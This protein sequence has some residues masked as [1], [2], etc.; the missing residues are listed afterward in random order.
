MEMPNNSRFSVAPER[1]IQR[2]T[3]D[4]PQSY[5]T[6][7]NAGDLIPIYWDEILPGDTVEMHN[8]MVVRESTPIHPVFGN[9]NVETFWF[10]VPNRLLWDDWEHFITGGLDA[11][12]W[13]TP[14]TYTPPTVHPQV[15]RGQLDYSESFRPKSLADYLGCPIGKDDNTNTMYCNVSALPFRAYAKIWNDWFRSAS[16][17]QEILIPKTGGRTDFNM[18]TRDQSTGVFS[19]S[20]TYSN[21]LTCVY[22]GSLLKANKYHDYF[23]SCLPEPQRG[24]TSAIPA[25]GS[26]RV[27]TAD[28]STLPA[29]NSFGSNNKYAAVF[30]SGSGTTSPSAA[31]PTDLYRYL[32]HNGSA[33]SAIQGGQALASSNDG[34]SPL[35]PLNLIANSSDGQSG[36][37]ISIND[38]RHAIA[39]QHILEIDARSG[40]GRYIDLIKGHF[41]VDSADA[42]LQRAEYLGGSSVPVNVQ[43]VLQTSSTNDISPQ[44]NTAAFSLTA[45]TDHPFTHSFTEHGIL[46]CLAVVRIKRSYQD[47]LARKWSRQSRY[48]YYWPSLANI[49][50]Q[51]VLNKEIFVTSVEEVN[52]EAFGYQEAFADYR[53]S[54]SLVTGAMR[55]TYAQSLDVWHYADDYSGTGRPYLSAEWLKEDNAEIDRTLAVSSSQADQFIG[56]F[57]FKPTWYRV[58]PVYSI[59]GLE[60]M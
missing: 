16:L 23:T 50:E 44:G 40:S 12:A 6:A 10:F 38:L 54:P 53:Y 43:Q 14:K 31:L 24:L 3:F 15:K 33:L 35:I 5:V 2:S 41:G 1:N 36:L 42:R 34:S 19:P 20:A 30:S 27:V 58:M 4:R 49:S 11:G 55:S 7:F 9:A 52:N 17:Q 47:G 28:P 18:G 37:T 32:F 59:P 22:G 45:D 29:L 60:R 13:D 46:M 8:G 56:D 48:D 57:A 25:E 39:V 21:P 26:L 51:A